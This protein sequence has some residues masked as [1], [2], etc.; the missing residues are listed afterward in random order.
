MGMKS[1]TS[2]VNWRVRKIDSIPACQPKELKASG[3]PADEGRA[4]RASNGG[5]GLKNMEA[6]ALSTRSVEWNGSECV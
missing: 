5:L 2:Q 1:G 6:R 3:P 4:H